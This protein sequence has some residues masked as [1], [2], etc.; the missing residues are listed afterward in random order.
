MFCVLQQSSF[1]TTILAINKWTQIKC[2]QSDREFQ[3]PWWVKWTRFHQMLHQFAGRTRY[4]AVLFAQDLQTCFNSILIQIKGRVLQTHSDVQKAQNRPI[5]PRYSIL[6][7]HINIAFYL[8][9]VSN[10]S[11][12][13][14]ILLQSSHLNFK[15]MELKESYVNFSRCS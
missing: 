14:L 13:S 9:V 5:F 10:L 6:W 11:D 12:I 2:Q 1:F 3:C 4:S 7:D 15:E 8:C